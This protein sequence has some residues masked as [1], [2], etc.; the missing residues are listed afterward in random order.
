MSEEEKKAI[1]DFKSEY[2]SCNYNNSDLIIELECAKILLNL[3]KK[4]QKEIK[5]MRK[6]LDLDEET[7]IALNNRIIDLEKEIDKQNKVIK[8]YETL[9]KR[10]EKLEQEKDILKKQGWL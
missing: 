3:I 8:E 9:L 10:Q 4:Q 5:D 2:D 6:E 7:E 1:D